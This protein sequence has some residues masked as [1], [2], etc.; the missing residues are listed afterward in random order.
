LHAYFV[1]AGDT[2]EPLVFAI[3]RV[4]DGRSMST[5]RVAVTQ[6]ARTLLVALASFHSNPTT[7]TLA[8]A[9]TTAVASPGAPSPLAGLRS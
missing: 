9:P 4:R 6:D 7:P 1:S 5:R 3:E 2:S 8:I